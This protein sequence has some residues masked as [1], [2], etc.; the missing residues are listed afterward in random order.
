MEN[1]MFG[2]MEI[3]MLGGFTISYDGQEIA[4]DAAAQPNLFSFF[5]SYGSMGK[6]ASR[7]NR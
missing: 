1:R 5:R 3:R 4:W 2:T 6:R 7:R